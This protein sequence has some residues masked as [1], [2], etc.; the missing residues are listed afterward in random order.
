M[1]IAP[2]TISARPAVTITPF[3][4][5]APESPA[6]NAN[7]TVRPSARPMTT[8]RTKSVAVKWRSRW[9]G[10]RPSSRRDDLRLHAHGTRDG[11]GDEAVLMRGLDERT[12]LREIAAGG[13]RDLRP[14]HDARHP[15]LAIDHRERADR[16][17]LV[18]HDRDPGAS[19]QRQVGEHLARLEGRHE[20]LLRVRARR[21]ALV[22]RRRRQ[23]DPWPPG[24]LD[25]MVPGRDALPAPSPAEL[26]P[27]FVRCRHGSLPPVPRRSPDTG[28]RPLLGMTPGCC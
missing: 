20:Q 4:A 28:R 2:A 27:V 13:H 8:S 21:I 6:A 18:G 12:G 7:G 1:A 16:I 26:R 11:A 14:Q 15:H 25:A 3:S 10:I 23:I 5:T 22:L 17:V 9:D 24:P 19:G